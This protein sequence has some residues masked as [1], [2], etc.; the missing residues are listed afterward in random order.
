LFVSGT[1]KDAVTTRASVITEKQVNPLAISKCA[2]HRHEVNRSRKNE[3]QQAFTAKVHS[4]LLVVFKFCY[5]P[6]N[7]PQELSLGRSDKVFA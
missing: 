3:K 2:F 7:Y 4:N 6:I 1:I 5:Q